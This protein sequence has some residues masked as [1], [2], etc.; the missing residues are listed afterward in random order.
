MTARLDMTVDRVT[1]ANGAPYSGALVYT[2]AAGTSTPKATYTDQARTTA[3]AN[4]IVCDAGGLVPLI[5][6]G[7][8]DYK[9]TFKT[10][11]GVLIRT[12]DNVPGNRGIETPWVTPEDYG[13][14]GDGATDDTA[15][16]QAAITALASTGGRV[17]FG[18]KPYLV[19][20][21]INV[22]FN[23]L[24]LIG[25]ARGQ[26]EAR[27]TQLVSATGGHDFLVLSNVSAYANFTV[28]N[29]TIG[30]AQGVTPTAGTAIKVNQGARCVID[31]VYLLRVWNGINAGGAN[32]LQVRDSVLEHVYGTEG[33]FLDE[34]TTAGSNY[35]L[36]NVKVFSGASTYRDGLVGVRC[37]GASTVNAVGVQVTRADRGFSFEKDTR[38]G[39]DHRSQFLYI[40]CCDVENCLVGWELKGYAR[41]RFANCAANSCGVSGDEANSGGWWIGTS[42]GDGGDATM[43]GCSSI[44]NYGHGVKIDVGAVSTTITGLVCSGNSVGAA[45]Y[46]GVYIT[47]GVDA[48]RIIGGQSGG[49]GT[50]AAPTGTATQRYG[51]NIAGNTSND[52]LVVGMDLRGNSTG[53]VN[54]AGD[55]ATTQVVN[56]PGATTIPGDVLPTFA[57][58]GL[59]SA[60][61]YLR[62]MIYVSDETGGAVPAFSD[63]TNWRR[64]TDRA[65]VS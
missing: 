58:A 49:S 60:S 11:A 14:A 15:A 17:M 55:P 52:I 53:A 25:A 48:V 31:N 6:L 4:P 35:T 54:N 38:G 29:M 21:A 61:Q 46:D 62:R 30:A 41:A 24:E 1:D 7:D 23:G 3:S 57:V 9:L 32:V 12:D 26:N 56:C 39:S 37:R 63:G 10:S 27:G 47:D 5:F 65:V 36:F 16:I 2:Y 45:S 28:R 19:S 20:D 64:V 34:Q 43:V 51:V 50:T 8:G 40:A 44:N 22:T 13:A 18:P 33:I 42:S 59:P